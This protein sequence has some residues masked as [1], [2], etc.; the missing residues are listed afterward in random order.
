MLHERNRENQ[1]D[2]EKSAWAKYILARM[3]LKP[4]SKAR[5]LCQTEFSRTRFIG[6]RESLRVCGNKSCFASPIEKIKR[7]NLVLQC[8]SDKSFPNHTYPLNYTYNL[9]TR[10]RA[11][12][13]ILSQKNLQHSFALFS[14]SLS[15]LFATLICARKAP[16]STPKSAAYPLYPKGAFSTKKIAL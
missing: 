16:F 7:G 8:E 3:T 5:E 9:F 1:T 6:H 4:T 2:G 10:S 11:I 14:P 13:D 15:Y 12:L